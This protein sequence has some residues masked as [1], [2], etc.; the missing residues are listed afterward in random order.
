VYMR[1]CVR[2]RVSAHTRV[3]MCV[4]VSEC[5]CVCASDVSQCWCSLLTFRTLFI[6]EL[7][8]NANSSLCLK[9]YDA[10]QHTS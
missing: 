7:K 10:V 4:C 1:E 2:A 5:V 6:P 3:C 9:H 8:A